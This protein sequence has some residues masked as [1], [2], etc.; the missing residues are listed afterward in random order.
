MAKKHTI[1]KDL[2]HI[3]RLKK[4]SRKTALQLLPLSVAFLFL[5][6]VFFSMSIMSGT[7][8]HSI[9]I[10]MAGVLGAYMALNIGANDLAN[11]VSPAVGSKAL[12]MAGALIIAAIFETAG[13]LIAGGDVVSTISKDIINKEAIQDSANFVIIM[14]SALLAGALWINLATWLGAPVSTTHSIVGGVLGSGVAAAGIYVVNWPVMGAI[15]ASW[16]ISPV[17]GGLLAAIFFAFLKKKIL[18]KEDMLAAAKNWVPIVLGIMASAFS[19]Y[20]IQKGFKKIWKPSSETLWLIG[21][22]LLITLPLVIRPFVIRKILTLENRAKS[23]NK[24][25]NLPLIFSAA[26]LSFAHGANDVA[27]AVGPLAAIV[28]TANGGG[29]SGSVGIPLWVMVIG[30]LGISIGLVLFGP[31]IVHT[32]GKKITKIDQLR[33][34]CIV[35]SA[36]I[37]VII[38]S[39]LGLPVSS[40]HIAVGGVFGVGLYREFSSHRRRHRALEIKAGKLQKRKLVRRR[41]LLSIIAAWVVTVPCAA[42]LSGLIYLLVSRLQSNVFVF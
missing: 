41:H 29:V 12:T 4:A 2:K 33:A 28:N 9:I 10:I 6:V 30:A 40:T 5:L 3:E 32:V 21:L 26:L 35:L 14:L 13:A 18:K 15:A 31:G 1:N 25:F 8:N 34:F 22:G 19:I 39:H 42:F 20:L 37:T 38:A 24:L 11:N 16:V 36:A 17:M 23:V 7:A 27:N